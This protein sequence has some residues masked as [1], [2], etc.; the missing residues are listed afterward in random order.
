MRDAIELDISNYTFDAHRL[1]TN[2][3]A[4][5]ANSATGLRVLHRWIGVQMPDLVV[6][7]ATDAY[8]AALEREFA[9][10]LPL[11]KVNPL[12]ARRFA[13]ARSTRVKTDAVD[14]RILAMMGASLDLVPDALAEKNQHALKELQIARM[15]L[16]K[17]RT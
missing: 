5:F 10:V 2:Q 16:I 17:E 6:C 15:A 12:Q 9:G 1:R 13:Q 3:A 8:H 11:V 14:A 4:N 7:E